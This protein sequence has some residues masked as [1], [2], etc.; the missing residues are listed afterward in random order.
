MK[1]AGLEHA[2]LRYAFLDCAR[3]QG[4]RLVQADLEMAHLW[5]ANLTGAILDVACLKAARPWSATLTNASLI[6]A[7]LT[8]ADFR[9]FDSLTDDDLPELRAWLKHMYPRQSEWDPSRFDT[10]GFQD[11]RK[12]L[13]IANKGKPPAK[14]PTDLS[15][16]KLRQANLYRANLSGALLQGAKVQ[17]AKLWAADLTNAQLQNANLTGADFRSFDEAC[18]EDLKGVQ[19]WLVAVY[20]R[21]LGDSREEAEKKA[22]LMG[23]DEIADF[24]GIDK[25]LRS[26]PTNLSGAELHDAALNG[27]YLHGVDLTKVKGLTPEQIKDAK[28][29]G[30]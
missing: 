27:T 23:K 17:H 20:E 1:N 26:R 7:D 5:G 11:I 21:R 10:M 28:G 19:D 3:L 4:A 8:G 9:S 30:V 14:R 13:R 2:N 16:A 25:N 29:V 24:L 22:Q 6:K 12:L 18:T 15:N